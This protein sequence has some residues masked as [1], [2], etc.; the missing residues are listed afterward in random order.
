MN[1][2]NLGKLPDDRRK[3]IQQAFGEALSEASEGG[4]LVIQAMEKALLLG[5]TQEEFDQF[6]DEVGRDFYSDPGAGRN[7]R[8]CCLQPEDQAAIEQEMDGFVRTSASEDEKIQ[9]ANNLHQL[10]NGSF[11]G[12]SRW[13]RIFIRLQEW[14]WSTPV[15]WRVVRWITTSREDREEEDRIIERLK[16]GGSDSSLEDDE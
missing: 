16:Q 6:L 15:L 5:V 1:D 11:R 3:L 13:R 4:N 14:C 7:L 2:E 9:I 12:L 10:R 8:E